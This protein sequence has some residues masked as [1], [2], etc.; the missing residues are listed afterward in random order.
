VSDPPSFAPRKDALPA[1]RQAYLKLHRLAAA[2]TMPGGLLCAAS[3]SSHFGRD[4]L[5]AS[6]KTAARQTACRWTLEGVYGAGFDH[7][8]LAAFPEGDYLTFAIG[9]ID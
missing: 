4:E 8:V 2:V 6:V 3:C 7:P 9:R 1:A 5:L